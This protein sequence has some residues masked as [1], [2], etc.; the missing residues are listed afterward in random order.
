[1]EE[2]NKEE[3]V[4]ITL[5]TQLPAAHGMRKKSSGLILGSS[6]MV[7]LTTSPLLAQ[8]HTTR[9]SL[10]H[11]RILNAGRLHH[12]LHRRR[13]LDLAAEN[14]HQTGSSLLP[15]QKKRKR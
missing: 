11:L 2:T 15:I 5:A 6:G 8:A 3:K 4:P 14:H 12:L 10:H 7:E 1:M 9:H 13:T